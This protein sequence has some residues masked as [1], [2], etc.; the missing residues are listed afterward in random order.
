MFELLE[1][2]GL[3]IRV[4]DEDKLSNDDFMGECYLPI[5][6]I[7]EQEQKRTDKGLSSELPREGAIHL[8]L[9]PRPNKKETVSGYLD[10]GYLLPPPST[11]Q[12]SQLSEN[13]I[14]LTSVTGQKVL[15]AKGSSHG[16]HTFCK[17][18]PFD[19][20]RVKKGKFNGNHGLWL[21]N[22]SRM[23]YRQASVV[24]QAVKELYGME[25][26]EFFDNKDSDTQAFGMYDS[27]VLIITYR[28]TESVQDMKSNLDFVPVSF[29]QSFPYQKLEY[30]QY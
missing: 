24:E 5:A 18:P 6:T 30:Y 19:L 7:L 2:T 9:H 16:I 4:F 11:L 26:F 23:V 15:K 10:I 17:L 21:S 13:S 25:G 12:Y 14:M 3:E 27:S 20:N 1:Y 22:A 8:A 29:L 28:G